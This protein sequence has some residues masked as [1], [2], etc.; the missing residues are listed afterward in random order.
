[1]FSGI[2]DAVGV[3]DTSD[4]TRGGRRLTVAVEGYWAELAE[5]ASVAIDGVC[6]M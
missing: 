3:V 1:M 2:I 5:G 6:L 4:S